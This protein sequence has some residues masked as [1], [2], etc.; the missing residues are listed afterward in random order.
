M[1][2]TGT[3][4]IISAP[5]GAGK[6]SLVAALIKE[7]KD[8]LVSVSHT[9]RQRRPNEQ[10]GLDYFFVTEQ[11]FKSMVGEGIFLEHAQVFGH[12]YGTSWQW[13]EEKLALGKDVILEIDWQG[14]RVVREK[15]FD[16]LSIFI[17]PPSEE[18]L[19]N[20]LTKRHQDNLTIIEQRMKEAKQEISKYKEYDYLICNDK[21]EEALADLKT[22][23]QSRRLRL[24]YA[25]KELA[26]CIKR[27]LS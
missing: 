15:Y 17:L 23:F 1:K 3:L 7:L 12:F 20:R 8:V 24:A 2:Y 26:D 5:S 14:A 27:L 19:L 22:L 18:E 25:E 11:E 16:T 4:Y 21:F 10:D 9:T 6:T 13:V